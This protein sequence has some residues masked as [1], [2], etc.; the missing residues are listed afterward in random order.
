MSSNEDL[1]LPN[2][3]YEGCTAAPFYYCSNCGKGY[4]EKHRQ[5]MNAQ[6]GGMVCRDCK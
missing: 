5:F 3:S 4:C 2:C 1:K 6:E